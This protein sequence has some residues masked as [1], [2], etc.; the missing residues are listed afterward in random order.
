M[1]VC[2]RSGSTGTP[3]VLRLERSILRRWP[4]AAAVTRSSTGFDAGAS[5][6]GRGDTQSALGEQ[7][8][9]QAAGPGADLDHR[10]YVERSGG[11]RDAPGQVE[12][13]DEVLPE[14]LLR[15]DAVAGDDVAQRRQ[16]GGAWGLARLIRHKRR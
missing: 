9:G 6:R 11:A 12:I 4:K 15:R 2:A 7:C 14:T 16:S 1:A 10:R 13:E 5:A 3:R 8:P